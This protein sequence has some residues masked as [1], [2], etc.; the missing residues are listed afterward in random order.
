M[1]NKLIVMLLTIVLIASFGFACSHTDEPTINLD[2][3]RRMMV[4]EV[5]KDIS[6]ELKQ[7]FVISHDDTFESITDNNIKICKV[8]NNSLLEN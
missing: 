3:E 2:Y 6:S 8:N 5:V 4:G 1:K 7:L